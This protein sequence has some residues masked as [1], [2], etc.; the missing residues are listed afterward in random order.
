M[1]QRLW[2]GLGLIFGLFALADLASLW[3]ANRVDIAL[4]TL[5]SG[6]EQ[7]RQATSDMRAELAA[8]AMAARQIVETGDPNH[9][10]SLNKCT[11]AFEAALAQYGARAA[12]ARG[13]ELTQQASTHFGRLKHYSQQLAQLTEQR[14]E[15]LEDLA[16]HFR[17]GDGL[18]TRMPLPAVPARESTSVQGL[19][20]ARDIAGMLRA[21]MVDVD[22]HAQAERKGLQWQFERDYVHFRLALKQYRASAQSRAERDWATWAAKWYAAM[23]AKTDRLIVLQNSELRTLS[24]LDMARNGLDALLTDDIQPAARA[25]LAVAV[26]RASR[27]AHDANLGITRALLLALVLGGLAAL[28]TMRAIKQAEKRLNYLAYHDALT[29]LPNR[30]LLDE[31]LHLALERARRSAQAVALLF[32]DLDDFKHVNDTLGHQEGDRLLE[33]MARRL[34]GCLRP[35]DVVARLGGDEFIVILEDIDQA[36]QAAPIAEQILNAISVPFEL[37]GIELRTSA[38]IGISLSPMHGSTSDE[39][40]KAA[41]AA[42]YRAKRGGGRS[43][44]FFSSELTK[45]AMEQLTL[46]NALRHPQ[47]PDQ[48]VLH[49]QPQVALDTG[50]IVGVE[51]LVRW[52]HPTQGLLSPAQFIPIAEEAGLVHLIGEWVLMAA[53]VQAKTWSDRGYPPVK[54]AINVSAQEVRTQ[55]LIERVERALAQT[56]LDASRLE[57]EVTESALQSGDDVLEVLVKLR[58]MGVLLALD[59]FGAGYSSFGSILSLP[60]H[61]LKID[62]SFVRNLQYGANDRSIAQAIIGLAHSLK[63]EVLAEGVETIAQLQILRDEGCHEVQGYLLGHPMLAEILD[64]QFADR[65]VRL[66]IPARERVKRLSVVHAVKEK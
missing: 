9:T 16:A 50:R 2:V 52:N 25:E 43:Y 41:D 60:F 17:E 45:Q 3:S 35:N 20:L 53:C 48:L 10:D 42:M 24:Q 59:D 56:G 32:I 18:L 49:Y 5:V 11:N 26:D 27:A 57:L 21:A 22:E 64:S 34:P 23:I 39:L 30:S 4:R 7:R 47:L 66:P 31:R 1:A 14:N 33:E 37:R 29:D 55:A 40:L 65:I 46:R 15:A 51:A 54:V 8:I 19:G 63:L 61:R 36:Q 13:K 44:Q 38:S 58:D 28:A 6:A 62:R 12:T